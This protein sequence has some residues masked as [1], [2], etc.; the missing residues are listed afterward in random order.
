VMR[1]DPGAAA[2]GPTVFS[3]PWPLSAWPE[4]PT[5]V[6]SGRDD[7]FFPLP[8]QQRVARDRLGI[9]AEE[10]PGGHLG[11]LSCPAALAD[12]ILRSR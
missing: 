12:R 9:E 1:A 8:L 3:Q 5:R 6:L 2:E 11:A 7:R 10:V 4:V